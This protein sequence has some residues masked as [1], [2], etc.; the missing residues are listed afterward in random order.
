MFGIENFAV[1]VA[2]SIALNLTPGQDSLFIVG[3]GVARG[4]VAGVSS[5]FGISAGSLIHT[6]AAA[7]GLSAVLAA[8]AT[9]FEA[10]KWVG[11]A[12]LIF[13]GVRMLLARDVELPAVSGGEG[14]EAVRW[15]SLAFRRGVMTNVLNPKV[16]VFFLAFLPQFVAADGANAI[17]PLLILGVTFIC[18]GTAWG[19]TL[20][21]MSARFSARARS[22]PDGL[23]WVR[24]LAGLL[25][26]GLGLRLAVSRSP[27]LAG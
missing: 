12:Y 13:L 25:F 17:V 14:P 5:A 3:Q 18:T 23:R 20:A 26:I 9:A 15:D 22:N 16:A 21:L 7:F 27:A 8:S 6:L 10:V 11:T 2:A 1:F 4:R 19:L 24:R